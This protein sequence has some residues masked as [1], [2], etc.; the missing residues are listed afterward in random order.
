MFLIL[1]ALIIAALMAVLLLRHA[2]DDRNGACFPAAVAGIVL[3]SLVGSLA[4]LYAYNAFTWFSAEHKA[5]IINREY[6]TNYTTSEIF[7][8]SDVI[9]TIHFH[10]SFHSAP[11]TFHPLSG[12][13]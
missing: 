2:M 5:D 4:M 13:H 12:R 3:S 10:P 7:W 1:I 11:L 6:G 8:A 9:D